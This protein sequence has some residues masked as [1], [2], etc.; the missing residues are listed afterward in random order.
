VSRAI[1][2]MASGIGVGGVVLLLVVAR[3]ESTRGV[4]LYG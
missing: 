1:V 3:K 2:L 4:M